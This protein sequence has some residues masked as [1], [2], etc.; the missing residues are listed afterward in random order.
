MSD[1]RLQHFMLPLVFLTCLACTDDGQP[2]ADEASGDTDATGTMDATDTGEGGNEA[3]CGDG[4]VDPMEDCDGALTLACSD[5]DPIYLSGAVACDPECRYDTSACAAG[6]LELE[7]CS[8]PALDFNHDVSASDSIVVDVGGTVVDVDVVLLV[9][10]SYL[11]DVHA[12]LGHSEAA[13]KLFG[14]ICGY[15]EDVD[16]TFDDE[17]RMPLTCTP[18]P[19]VPDPPAA[20]LGTMGPQEPLSIF[21][22]LPAAGEWTLGLWDDFG[23]NDGTLDSWCLRLTV[24]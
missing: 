2:G 13:A 10:H 4:V 7:L 21:D 6:P 22:G 17:A 20:I 11:E 24:E 1:R 8:T 23:L 18:P 9:T 3:I 19:I 15:N 5:Y 14:D 16:A 12:N